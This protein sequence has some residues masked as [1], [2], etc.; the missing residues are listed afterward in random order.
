MERTVMRKYNKRLEL[1]EQVLAVMMQH[2]EALSGA[3]ENLIK[4]TQVNASILSA[5][6]ERLEK[7]EGDKDA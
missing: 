7:L 1:I 3:V 6:N 4:A 2:T 5:F